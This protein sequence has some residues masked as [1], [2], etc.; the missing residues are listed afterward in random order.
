MQTDPDHE[1]LMEDAAIE[2]W[3][4]AGAPTPMAM[5][6]EL[7]RQSNGEAASADLPEWLTVK[8]VAERYRW[9]AKTVRKDIREKRLI[10]SNAAPGRP[11]RIRRSD[12]DAW[13]EARRAPNRRKPTQRPQRRTG[14]K[15]TGSFRDLVQKPR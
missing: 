10:A 12:A 13:A 9:S 3:K 15:A 2:D 1:H 4:D 14:T 7:Q 6:Q 5:W 11:Y 8:E